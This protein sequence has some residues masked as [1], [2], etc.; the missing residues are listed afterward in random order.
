M[1]Q[2]I[3]TWSHAPNAMRLLRALIALI[4]LTGTGLARA[5]TPTVYWASGFPSFD[6]DH[7]VAQEGERTLRI[8]IAALGDSIADASIQITLPTDVTYVPGSAVAAPVGSAT[9]TVT[10]GPSDVT[11]KITSDGGKLPL[12]KELEFHL[13]VKASICPTPASVS[14]GINVLSSSTP[15][16]S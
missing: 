13:K 12:N 9:F 10:S 16:G 5:Q 14:F 3:T 8:R 2:K 11:L 15:L 6:N 1:K 4:L 7:I